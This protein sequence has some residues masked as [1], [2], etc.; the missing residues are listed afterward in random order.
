MPSIHTRART[1]SPIESSRAEGDLVVGPR[2][3]GVDGAARVLGVRDRLRAPLLEVLRAV[4]GAAARLAVA[5]V[6][7][8]GLAPLLERAVEGDLLHGA[9]RPAAGALAGAVS[10]G[11][12][13]HGRVEPVHERDVEVVHRLPQRVLGQRDGLRPDPPAHQRAA[14]VARL[15]LPQRPVD[16]EP[17]P[18]AAPHA[19]VLRAGGHVDEPRVPR[20]ELRAAAGNRR[21]VDGVAALV[22]D[23]DAHGVRARHGG[24]EQS[25]D[26]QLGGCHF[27]CLFFCDVWNGRTRWVGYL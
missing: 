24:Q 10:R 12:E 2:G 5:G 6:A 22:R 8:P 25:D 19:T 14:A 23:H 11:E 3:A 13:R 18:R 26:A 20:V 4:V 15:A 9:R 21:G 7:A 1:K 17:A 16:D 27:C